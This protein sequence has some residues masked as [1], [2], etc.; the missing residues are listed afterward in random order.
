MVFVASICFSGRIIESD[1]P[2]KTFDVN[3]FIDFIEINSGLYPEKNSDIKLYNYN[4]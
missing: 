1:P 4:K 2:P 3:S